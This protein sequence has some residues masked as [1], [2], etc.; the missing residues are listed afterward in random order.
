M[1][2]QQT[3]DR[4]AFHAE[5]LRGIGGSDAPVILGLSSWKTPL[6]LWMEKTGRTE[7]DVKESAILRRGRKLEP[8]VASEYEEETGRRVHDAPGLM[9]HATWPW[10]IGHLDRWVEADDKPGPGVLECKAAN[11]FK[12]RDW[13][14]EAPLYAQVQAQHYIAVSGAAWGSVAG[15]LGGIEF[16][17]QDLDRNDEFIAQLVEREAAFWRLVET[18]TP[19]EPEAADSAVLGRLYAAVTGQ[20]VD[21][22]EAAIEWDRARLEASTEIKRLEEL[23]DEA[24]AQLK[25]AIGHAEAGR[26][27]NGIVYTWKEQQRKEYVVKA[28]AFRVLRRS[29]K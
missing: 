19:P 2:A 17:Y 22:P 25:A 10:M 21:L 29:A 23:K 27:P 18:D 24:D 11:V 6:Q 14:D 13:D 26:L 1:E 8:V 20:V 7:P 12:I 3:H 5:R 4:A 9:V 16:K 15:L 28:A